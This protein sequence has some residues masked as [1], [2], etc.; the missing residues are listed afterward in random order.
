MKNVGD[1]YEKLAIKFLEKRGFLILATKA[2]WQKSEIDIICAKGE[3][4]FAIEVKHRKQ[5]SFLKIS[6]NQ[7]KKIEDYMFYHFPGK[8]FEFFIIFF[9]KNQPK[10]L[11]VL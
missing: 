3:R 10:I 4:I 9:E 5:D 1:F 8:F 6:A 7:L 11:Y 2:R